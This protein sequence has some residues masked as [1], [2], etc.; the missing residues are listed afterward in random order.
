[1]NPVLE[2]RNIAKRFGAVVALSDGGVTV[3]PGEIHALLG[4]NGCGKS[5]LCKI[6]AGS[7][8]PDGGRIR[9]DATDAS[10]RSPREAE[11]HGIGLFYQ[12]LSLVP[13]LTVEANIFLGHE[14]RRAGFI[15]R[16]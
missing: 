10:F 3:W 1:M 4:A 16:R 12:E 6:L 2:A 5:T 7:V 15:D 9:I 14:P 11:A 8:R 13:Q